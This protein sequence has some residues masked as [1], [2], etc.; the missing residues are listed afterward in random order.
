MKM[1]ISVDTSVA[2]K[3]VKNRNDQSATITAMKYHVN[4]S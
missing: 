3:L 1:L 4:T 2:H